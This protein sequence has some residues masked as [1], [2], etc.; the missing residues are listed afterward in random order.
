[1]TTEREIEEL[2]VKAKSQGLHMTASQL[3]NHEAFHLLYRIRRLE[4]DYYDD[5]R[6]PGLIVQMNAHFRL[7]IKKMP[8]P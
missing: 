3:H 5:A 7:A 2:A 4:A 8:Q 1:M 6:I